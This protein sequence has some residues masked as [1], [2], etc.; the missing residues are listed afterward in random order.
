[1]IFKY[2]L[3]FENYNIDFRAI[4]SNTQIFYL[5]SPI[6]LSKEGI[7]KGR[8]EIAVHCMLGLQKGLV[9]DSGLQLVGSLEFSFS[10]ESSKF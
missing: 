7:R 8:W 3:G 1:M 5:C 4:G 10:V 9:E 2:I 6:P